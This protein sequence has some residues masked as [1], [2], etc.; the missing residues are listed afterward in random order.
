MFYEFTNS[1]RKRKLGRKSFLMLKYAFFVSMKKLYGQKIFVM[2]SVDD[3]DME[4]EQEVDDNFNGDGDEDGDGNNALDQSFDT[5]ADDSYEDIYLMHLE[6]TVR[7]VEESQAAGIRTV[8]IPLPPPRNNSRSTTKVL[9][10]SSYSSIPSSSHVVKSKNSRPS[11]SKPTG[12]GTAANAMNSMV[13]V[14]KESL[15]HRQQMNFLNKQQH[16]MI[17]FM[18]DHQE[19]NAEE[20]RRRSDL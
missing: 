1:L 15:L 13:E 6:D 14:M 11:G 20:D 19:K 7:I 2:S 5:Y 4:E 16:D 10:R 12:R 8:D 9:N 3:D 17:K 18:L